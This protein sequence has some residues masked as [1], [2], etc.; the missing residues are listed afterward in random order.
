LLS[1]TPE[2]LPT[3]NPGANF[4][5]PEVKRG[6]V[7]LSEAFPH[8]TRPSV[9]PNRDLPEFEP[10]R[11]TPLN[12]GEDPSVQKIR[13]ANVLSTALVPKGE[14]AAASQRAQTA[15]FL[16]SL[17]AE[18]SEIRRPEALIAR[19]NSFLDSNPANAY[20]PSLRA[21]LARQ[22]FEA[23]YFSKALNAW[24]VAWS[25]LE[26]ETEPETKA[27]A[28]QVLGEY[29][30][31]LGRV[32]RMDE[33]GGLLHSVRDRVIMGSAS[34][35]VASAREGFWSMEN[36]PG[37]SFLCGPLALANC[38]ERLGL[39]PE[40]EG[41]NAIR[42]LR[43]TP[44]GI[45][46]ST[47]IDA[48]EKA[49]MNYM[50]V[51]REPGAPIPDRFFPM[52]VHWKLD[53]YGCLTERQG[54]RFKLVDPTF[55]AEISLTPKA[56]DS[57]ASGY[58]LVPEGK[59]PRGWRE[60]SQQE[61]AGVFG[62]GNPG[63]KDTSGCEGSEGGSDCD[64]TGMAT[65]SFSPL[66]IG[67]LM[68]DIPVG[69]TPPVGDPVNFM[70]S[71]DQRDDN[72][73]A[74]FTYT[75]FGPK[76]TFGYTAY[77]EDDTT[78][79]NG[80]VIRYRNGTRYEF[81]GF[82]PVSGKYDFTT[83]TRLLLE[84]VS[85]SP[86]RYELTYPDGAIMVFEASDGTVGAG[87]KVF[88]SEMRDPRGNGVTLSY[89]SQMRLVAITDQL[90]QVSVLSYDHPSDPLKVT[91]ITDPFGRSGTF[92]YDSL[93]RLIRITDVL[94]LS[95]DFEYGEGDF[96]QALVTPYGRTTFEYGEEGPRRWLVATDPYGDRERI[97]FR[98]HDVPNDDR[99]FPI[100]DFAPVAPTNFSS[101]NIS[102]AFL[103]E[104]NT[105]YWD[106]K[107]IRDAEMLGYTLSDEEFHEM[108]KVTHWLHKGVL[109][110]PIT[111]IP[112][113]R[114]MALE[115]R[116]WYTYPGQTND[117]IANAGMLGRPK[118]IGRVLDDGSNYT[119]KFSYNDF[120]KVTEM[121]D[122]ESRNFTFVYAANGIDLLEVRQTY[123][124]NN[125]LMRE[126]ANYNSQY[127]PQTITDGS[128]QST[129]IAYTTWGQPSLVT[130]PLGEKTRFTYDKDLDG[131]ADA[132]GG[133][134]IKVE[135][136][137]PTNASAFVTI[138]EMT[139]GSDGNI[140]TTTDESGYTLDY[141]FD[142]FDRLVT[143]TYPDTTTDEFFYDRLD[144]AGTKDRED[145]QSRIFRD[146]LRRVVAE[147]DPLGRTT[148]YVWCVC[149]SLSR[150]IDANG[151]VTRWKR[152]VQGRVT[153]KIHPDG[154]SYF[155]TYTD[156][157]GWLET[158]TDSLNQIT[159]YGHEN[160]GNVA[161][162]TYTNEINATPDVTF[163]YAQDYDRLTQMTDGTGATTF[164]YHPYDGTTLGAGLLAEVN[165]PLNSDIIRYEY[166]ELGRL[167]SREVNN[168]ATTMVYD[169]LGRVTSVTNPLGTFVRTYSG[170]SGRLTSLAY[171]N[172]QDTTY[173]Y[174]GATGDFRLQ[175]IDNR[176]AANAI[177]S[178][179]DYAYS[180]VGNI[181]EWNQQLGTAIDRDGDYRYDRANQLIGADYRNPSTQDIQKQFGYVYDP[182]GN[183]L[184]E[185][186]HTGAITETIWSSEFNAEEGKGGFVSG[187]VE[188]V[189]TAGVDWSVGLSG[190][191]LANDS[192]DDWFR[193][194]NG[195]FEGRDL[196]GDAVWLSPLIDISNHSDVAFEV[197]VS[198]DGNHEST[199][200]LHVSYT[201]DGGSTVTDITNWNG[202]GDGT[203]SLVDDWTSETI[204]ASGLSGTD[205][206]LDV[207][208]RNNA[209]T[210]RLR[211]EQA[212]VTGVAEPRTAITEANFNE[213]NQMVSRGGGGE[214]LFSGT[215]DEPATVTV[216]GTDA[217]LGNGGQSF[218]ARVDLPTGTSTV[219]V[220][221]TDV[222]SNTTSQDYE[223]EVAA[224]SGQSLTYDANGNMTD[225]GSGQT[226]KW[227]AENRLIEITRGT[228][229]T[230]FAYDGMS[231]R[232]RIT[233]KSSGVTV[234]DHHYI[235]DGA[236]IVERRAANGT[237]WEQ[238]Y[239]AE[240]FVDA[241]EGD[242]YYTRDHLGSVREVVADDGVSVESQY[243]YGIWGEVERIAGVR[244][245]SS[246]RYTGHFYH[247]PSEL[248]LTWFRAYDADLGRWLSRDPIG[249]A[250]GLNLY[251]YVEGNPLRY[252]DPLGLIIMAP[253]AAAGLPNTSSGQ[254]VGCYRSRPLNENSPF[255]GFGG[256]YF[257]HWFINLDDGTRLSHGGRSDPLPGD[258]VVPLIIPAE[259]DPGDFAQKLKE[260]WPDPSEYDPISDNC[261]QGM[262]RAVQKTIDDLTPRKRRK[263]SFLDHFIF[264]L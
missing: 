53:H 69:Y 101:P 184:S 148:N 111:S 46:L 51:K 205:F 256:G 28:D 78:D 254:R 166:D 93:G 239:Y 124:S 97:E 171:P 259:I 258:R 194:E 31:M 159:T 63:Q 199:D 82:D 11:E 180:P 248:H 67:L 236:D 73:P 113:S 112:G 241:T 218:A 10:L 206:Q 123:G 216:D 167:D 12:L 43:S 212:K 203:H 37:I 34:E 121:T 208:M 16:E 44:E 70:V 226:Y 163:S 100:P 103:S 178:K 13:S 90:G 200:T 207:E 173:S 232:V 151:N 230:E 182:L 153:E 249:E 211:L 196:D 88:L 118:Q 225:N 172:G 135:R 179:F 139:Y 138:A 255:T 231:R 204:T 174:L 245:E 19:M 263:S 84:K 23:G 247:A 130:N 220:E 87:R 246:F 104:R 202:L 235:W 17:S 210:E 25:E 122:P 119:L 85:A 64:G 62:R 56:L 244:E 76:W 193:V 175:T 162:I 110:G 136:T 106:K 66:L 217:I 221:A 27:L 240:G 185:T 26:D 83:E 165:G 5:E 188:T 81:S 154:N 125:E 15:R 109:H 9:E 227:D 80:T 156:A 38:Y 75:N 243:D 128:G 1:Q 42:G 169:S 170:N 91:G 52:V 49:E 144:L 6:G 72:Q 186:V 14:T 24:R 252:T 40:S 250:A 192:T 141:T 29:A 96:I 181:T 160:D 132:E 77:I 74:N 102:N 95:S 264:L 191:D 114:K 7:N 116:E 222:N 142:V 260:N 238:R 161:S 86:I 94:G 21:N 176:D 223:V 164:D 253:D 234:E 233:E 61:A 131:V 213:L 105:F 71:Y 22:Y 251:G 2:S 50:A 146:A 237:S 98:N 201:T 115:R 137:D 54:N 65:Y 33:L 68:R 60:V 190:V 215:T 158:R 32:G 198:E 129:T 219:T 3:P 149:G 41:I 48:A 177:L 157:L 8:R 195:V 257:D 79:P 133:Y 152:D 55:L 145:R 92:E 209:D 140:A 58:F 108:A 18:G 183:R 4:S 35:Y 228:E 126:Y 127:L 224:G 39:D 47:L 59:L 45:A 147:V 189:D 242:F 155:Y 168:I 187:G 150:L 262:G 107:A 36:D 30:R 229:T 89:D 99:D 261:R 20:S 143:I 120:G 57:E 197:D 134:L 117:K 214:T